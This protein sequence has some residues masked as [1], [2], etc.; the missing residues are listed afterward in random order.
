MQRLY[1]LQKKNAA[2][3][4]VFIF[5]FELAWT[6][7]EPHAPDEGKNLLYRKAIY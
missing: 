3:S 1:K 7:A 5:I 6:L 4:V 2:L